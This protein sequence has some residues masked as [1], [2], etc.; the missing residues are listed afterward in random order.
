MWA[1]LAYELRFQRTSRELKLREAGKIC[2]VTAQTF[3]NWE[4]GRRKPDSDQCDRLDAAWGTG[5]VLA[6]IHFYGRTAHDPD[7][8]GSYLAYEKSAIELRIYQGQLVPTL[9][10]T[11]GYMRVLFEAAG[12]EDIERAVRERLERQKA[13]LQKAN[14]PLIWLILDECVLR[15]LVGGPHVMRDQFAALLELGQLRHIIIRISPDSEG[16]HVGLDGSFQILTT[17]AQDVVFVSAP[18]GGRLVQDADEVRRFEVRFARIGAKALTEESSRG[19]IRH[20]ME[21]ITG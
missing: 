3:S 1:W 11:E 14:P 19:K 18:E 6:R 7:W 21:M 16:A 12:V 10:Q 9:F 20:M 4:A 17:D 5:G 13:V 8:Y 2:N 15:R